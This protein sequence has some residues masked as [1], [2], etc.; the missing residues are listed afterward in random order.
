MLVTSRPNGE[1]QISDHSRVTR[2]KLKRLARDQVIELVATLTGGKCLP[3]ALLD[4]IVSKSD[5]VPLF[6][7]ELTKAVLGSGLLHETKDGFLLDQ[8]LG[9]LS[10]PTS[11]HDSL[12][13]R[14]D[15]L[16]P[17]KEIAQTAAC[18]GREFSHA[19]ILAVATFSKEEL[20]DAL[21]RLLAAELIF[22]RGSRQG[23][24]YLFKH[25]LVRDAAYE[26][27]LKSRRGELHARIGHIL[28][29]QFS[30]LAREEPELL[31]HHFDAAGLPEKAVIYWEKAGQ[32][33]SSHSAYEEALVHF[34]KGIQTLKCLPSG[35]ARMQHEL[36]LRADYAGVLAAARGYVGRETKEAYVRLHELCEALHDPPEA[37][38]VLRGMFN[39]HMI[40]AEYSAAHQIAVDCLKLAKKQD[41][42][43]PLSLAHRLVGHTLFRMGKLKRARSNLQQAFDLY[44]D[45][46]DR[47]NKLI[48]GV[49]LK[50]GAL[51]F[52]SQALC[53][54]GYPDQAL[55]AVK[56]SFNHAKKLDDAFNRALAMNFG[57]YVRELR[58]EYRIA[59]VQSMKMRSLAIDHGLSYLAAEATGHQLRA[60]VGI[61][62]RNE[63]TVLALTEHLQAMRSTGALQWFSENLMALA[64]LLAGLKKWDQALIAIDE[65][66]MHTENSN[67][68]HCQAELK[69]TKGELLLARRKSSCASDAEAYLIQ[70]LDVARNQGARLWELR[71][72]LSMARLWAKLGDQQRAHDILA[73]IYSRFSEG[74]DTRDLKDAKTFLEEIGK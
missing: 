65:A 43:E 10:V 16:Q 56:D 18:I 52:L 36:R 22:Q 42:W 59:L 20:Q 74:F 15:R 7:E 12:M 73:P 63:S 48:Y 17:V 24:A 68:R 44:D 4:E 33:A 31:A 67:E 58:R 47:Q 66:L 5:G 71:S 6:V 53:L 8:S 35:D 37:F 38:H 40:R 27:L 62:E 54:L 3:K 61:G 34:E 21:D 41:E 49:D 39:F 19:Q 72:T 64:Q 46:Q 25:A 50:I 9:R 69:R 1:P 28:E 32:R 45:Q 23:I 60:K 55:A 70:S 29:R 11:L 14:L 26:S 57:C 30:E 13:A 51:M 2:V